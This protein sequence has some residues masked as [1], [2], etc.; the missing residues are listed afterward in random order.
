LFDHGEE[1]V[2]E[3]VPGFDF[4]E[5]RALKFGVGGVVLD[6]GAEA[7]EMSVGVFEVRFDA[8]AEEAVGEAAEVE[9]SLE[10]L[11][12]HA[13]QEDA[14]DGAELA[15]PFESLERAPA[16]GAEQ[17][18]DFIEVERPLGGE[19]QAID[20]PDRT[21][22]RE[23]ASGTDEESDGLLLERVQGG[24]GGYRQCRPGGFT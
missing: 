6:D 12:A 17:S 23:C 24:S 1:V 20:L 11:F 4:A 3:A 7:V 18:H 22:Q 9:F 5:A 21:R 10:M 16:A 14:L 15:E 2:E 8:E 19:K 13:G